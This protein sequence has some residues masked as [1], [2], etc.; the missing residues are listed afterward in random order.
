MKNKITTE[1]YTVK[2]QKRFTD[3][4]DDI[5][6]AHILSMFNEIDKK[7]KYLNSGG[8]AVVAYSIV[9]YAKLLGI[10]AKVQ[11]LFNGWSQSDYHKLQNN[12]NGSCSHAVVVINNKM[13]DS[14]GLFD[15]EDF[16]GNTDGVTALDLEQD[17]VLESISYPR[18]WNHTFDRRDG[19]KKIQGVLKIPIK[20]TKYSLSVRAA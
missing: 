10:D 1:E 17:R 8:C 14:N 7:V 3:Y 13:Y 15:L 11:Y 5:K 19:R 6:I 12:E 18:H 2:L 16:F 20:I 9:E 4:S